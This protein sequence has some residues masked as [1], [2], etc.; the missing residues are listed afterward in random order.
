MASSMRLP[1]LGGGGGGSGGSGSPPASDTRR[2]AAKFMDQTF[3]LLDTNSVALTDTNLYNAC[4]AFP[5]DTNTVPDLQIAPYGTGS[6]LIKANH[7]NYSAETLRDFALL[8][9]DDPSK[10]TWKNIDLSGA[11]D[12][13]DGWLVQGTVANWQVTDPMFLM[14]GNIATNV[15][16]FF[17]AIPYGGAQVALTGAAPYNTVSNTI[18]LQAVI[19]DLSG[20]TN[21]QF[22]INVDQLPARYSMGTSNTI[23]IQTPYNPNGLHNINATASCNNARV[24]D[25]NNIPDNAKLFF[26]GTTNL[27]LD[28]ENDTYLAF[29]SDMCPTN[30]GTNYILFVVSKPQEIAATI[31]DPANGNVVASYGGYVPYPATV[32]IPWNFTEGDGV[33]PYSNDTYVVSFTAY[34]PITLTITN[35]LERNG[36]RPGAGCLMTYEWE[37]P[38]DPTGSYLNSQAYTWIDQTLLFLFQDLYDPYGITQYTGGTDCGIN[39]DTPICSP[40]TSSST[41]WMPILQNLTNV[42]I[43]EFTVAQAHG[44]GGTIGGGSYLPPTFSPQDLK[45]QVISYPDHH[46]NRLRKA[47]LWACYSGVIGTAVSASANYPSFID[48]CGITTN[49]YAAFQHKNCGFFIGGLLPQGGY[50]A[51]QGL[52]AVTAEVAD[53]LDDVWVTGKNEYPGGCDPTYSFNF[54]IQSTVNFYPELQKAY[55]IGAGYLEC[56]YSSLYDDEISVL[57]LTHVNDN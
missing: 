57:N 26:S 41:S 2:N 43:S 56:V 47:A 46:H 54:A 30:V 10:P 5:N 1:T 7:F 39:R 3:S 32:Q 31:T 36:I 27:P 23:S 40:F 17:R 18:M 33:T 50:G 11:S 25:T 6:I 55:P 52:N 37:N 22:G 48:A 38:S 13:Q 51:A 21:E 29:A 53:F 12:S 15:N 35:M 4:L 45:L 44:S 34:D 20:T 24:Y 14:I 42:T 9:C 28:F 8:V 19:M 16:A 49:Q